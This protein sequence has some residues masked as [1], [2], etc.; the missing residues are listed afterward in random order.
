MKSERSGSRGAFGG[1]DR[2][3]LINRWTRFA[4]SKKAKELGS[5]DDLKQNGVPFTIAHRSAPT[6]RRGGAVPSQLVELV[7]Y[8]S[9]LV[10]IDE[11][12]IRLGRRPFQGLQWAQSCGSGWRCPPVH[13]TP[14][15]FG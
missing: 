3:R 10:G 6:I 1:S 15:T 4:S 12:W 13:L 11:L 9:P 5:R 8:W 14:V 7:L 2:E